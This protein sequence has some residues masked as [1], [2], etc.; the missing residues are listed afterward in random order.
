MKHGLFG[1]VVIAGLAVPA[2]AAEPAALTITAPKPYQVVQRDGD[3][4]DVVVRADFAK[5]RTWEYRVVPLPVAPGREP[6]WTEFDAGAATPSVRVPAGGWYRLEIRGRMKADVT[7]CGSVEPVG[8]GEVFLVA[9][10]SYATNCNDE[11]LKV[12]DPRLRV[13]AF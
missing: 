13:V 5:G 6:G 12:A 4:A 1:C 8:V 11:R 10:Q 3:G 9:G 2:L 7:H